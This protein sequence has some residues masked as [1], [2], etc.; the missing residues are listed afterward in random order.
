MERC[1]D[2]KQLWLVEDEGMEKRSSIRLLCLLTSV[3][4]ADWVKPSYLS[5]STYPGPNRR[6][7]HH[8]I[9]ADVLRLASQEFG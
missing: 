2:G 1:K 6:N 7:F 4:M 8:S 3:Q 5:T 9:E